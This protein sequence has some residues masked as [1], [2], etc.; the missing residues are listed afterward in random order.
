LTDWA[1]SGTILPMRYMPSLLRFVV[2]LGRVY[3]NGQITAR[4]GLTQYECQ[5]Q[6]RTWKN[7]ENRHSKLL[8]PEYKAHLGFKKMLPGPEVSER[9][10]GILPFSLASAFGEWKQTI[11]FQ[12]DLGFDINQGGVWKGCGPY[13]GGGIFRLQQPQM[14]DY[15]EEKGNAPFYEV[16]QRTS[17]FYPGETKRIHFFGLYLSRYIG[18]GL[19]VSLS[20]PYQ[21]YLRSKWIE[22]AL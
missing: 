19:L 3:W 5:I 17:A 12:T 1:R 15:P 18:A 10:W 7:F 4:H 14:K 20:D 8:P 13:S 21:N 11:P 22:I 6:D 2:R 16:W 9:K